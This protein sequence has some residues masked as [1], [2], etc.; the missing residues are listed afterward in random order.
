MWVQVRAEVRAPLAG[1]P[2]VFHPAFVPGRP[3]SI[4]A[5]AEGPVPFDAPC[6]VYSEED[7]RAFEAFVRP[8]ERCMASSP[9]LYVTPSHCL[10]FILLGGSGQAPLFGMQAPPAPRP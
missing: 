10:S 4:I 2:P 7:E 6:I 5:H 8:R 9:V 3:V 1:E